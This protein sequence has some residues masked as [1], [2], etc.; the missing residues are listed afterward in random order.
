MLFVMEIWISVNVLAQFDYYISCS[1]F[2][3][4][5][6]G[7][8]SKEYIL[9]TLVATVAPK[10]FIPLNVSSLLYFHY[11]TANECFYQQCQFMGELG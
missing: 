8:Y 9:K 10:V 5:Y 6:G 3:I 11:V 4:P 7:K 1:C 2:Q